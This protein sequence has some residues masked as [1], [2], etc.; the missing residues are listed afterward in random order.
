MLRDTRDLSLKNAF[1]QVAR[2]LLA[3]TL[4]PQPIALGRILSAQGPR[5]PE[6]AELAVRE[7]YGRQLRVLEL[8]LTRF[9]ACGDFREARPITRDR[10]RSAAV[11]TSTRKR[12]ILT[13]FGIS[14]Y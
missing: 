12:M 13:Y 7:G 9:E 4:S 3:S 6:L 8:V 10:K 5:F 2:R 11:V 14:S 1:R